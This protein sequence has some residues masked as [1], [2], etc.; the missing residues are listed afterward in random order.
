ME[1]IEQKAN[2]QLK[3]RVTRRKLFKSMEEARNAIPE[4]VRKKLG[5][6][7]DKGVEIKDSAE[8]KLP[9]NNKEIPLSAASRRLNEAIFKALGV[10][11]NIT[12]QIV[13]I[14][15]AWHTNKKHGV[16]KEKRLN[17]IPVTRETFMLIPDVLKN[18]DTVERG[19]DTWIND[20]R[21]SSVVIGKYYSDGR[22]VLANAIINNNKLKIQTM[23]IE[24]PTAVSPRNAK[25]PS[26]SRLSPSP[27]DLTVSRSH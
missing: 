20:K 8:S 26:D 19:M 14:K 7:W 6:I 15:R 12:E 1:K 25:T 3:A 5:N 16:G 17:Q 4:G 24:K 21:K 11:M 10:K 18:F 13:T 2:C 27:S 22:I 9:V 23:W